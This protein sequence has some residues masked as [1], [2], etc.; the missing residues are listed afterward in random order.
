MK[1]LAFFAFLILSYQT[2]YAETPL[3]E[4]TCIPVKVIDGTRHV[5]LSLELAVT[6]DAVQHGLM[7]RDYLG[8]YNGMIFIFSP[9]QET[10]MWMKNTYIPLDML[11]IDANEKI[12]KVHEDAIPHDLTPIWSGGTAQYVIELPNG[13]IERFDLK[14]GQKLKLPPN[15]FNGL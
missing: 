6:P 13:A 14:K 5:D 9:P 4:Q 12:I 11:F 15:L 2:A 10:A 3:Y 1:Y 7:F 8:L